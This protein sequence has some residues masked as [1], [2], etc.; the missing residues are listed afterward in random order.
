MLVASVL[1]GIRTGNEEGARLVRSHYV[2]TAPSG[3]CIAYCVAYC[4]AY[5]S[6]AA[7]SAV[8]YQASGIQSDCV[9]AL[10]VGRILMPL[11]NPVTWL[12]SARKSKP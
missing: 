10:A 8:V 4:V 2:E 5:G 6:E 11:G 12:K 9:S 3:G 7:S 1:V